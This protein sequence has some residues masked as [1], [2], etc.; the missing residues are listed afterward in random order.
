MA[1]ISKANKDGTYDIRFED[2]EKELFVD[3]SQLFTKEEVYG[4]GGGAGPGRG[5]QQQQEEEKDDE[6]ALRVGDTVMVHAPDGGSIQGLVCKIHPATG[7]FN[8][9]FQDGS[10]TKDVPRASLTKIPS[11]EVD[12]NNATAIEDYIEAEDSSD[13]PSGHHADHNNNKV[14]SDDELYQDQDDDSFAAGGSGGGSG[15]A[16]RFDSVQY[17][18]HGRVIDQEGS[19]FM[20][21]SVRLSVWSHWWQRA[22]S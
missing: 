19:L 16:G 14:L 1:R 15:G 13:A 9:K 2:G 7:G 11:M 8:V 5:G 6:T 22:A 21:A 10:V 18:M 17:D 4:P 20:T 12:L 3:P